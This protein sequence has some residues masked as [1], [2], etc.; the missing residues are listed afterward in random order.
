MEIN[1]LDWKF[2]LFLILIIVVIRWIWV[3]NGNTRHE[4][5]GLRGFRNNN[6]SA[7]TMKIEEIKECIPDPDVAPMA[8]SLIHNNKRKNKVEVV[9]AN[10]F[11]PTDNSKT[12]LLNNGNS[13]I[14][15][16]L[17][18]EAFKVLI[19]N[20]KIVKNIRPKFLTNPNT[21]RALE[22]DC[23]CP[24]LGCGVEYNGLQHYEY[25]NIF[26]KSEEE[27][28]QQVERDLI[29][30][31]LADLNG[32]PIF[33]VPCT[34]DSV[35]FDPQSQKYNHI[36]R[37]RQKRYELIYNYLKEK[38]APFLNEHASSPLYLDDEVEEIDEVDEIDEQ[39]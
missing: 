39:D 34:V 17:T 31:E 8:I 16:H 21:G 27:F 11:N 22:I 4:F 26:N 24:E 19:G 6:E 15:E 12:N 30:R 35:V 5:I 18:C 10:K 36:K 28:E 3:R 20:R 7:E 25:P 23:Y 33:T 9:I 2:W 14:G 29:K 32:T 38:M 37:S 1:F 13:S